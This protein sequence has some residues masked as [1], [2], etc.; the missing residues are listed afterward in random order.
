ML[1]VLP[2][3][4][5]TSAQRTPTRAGTLPRRTLHASSAPPLFHPTLCPLASHLAG[6]S[7]SGLFFSKHGGIVGQV[8]VHHFI[9]GEEEEIGLGT[10]N[11]LC[12]IP[13][14]KAKEKWLRR[15]QSWDQEPLVFILSTDLGGDIEE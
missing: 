7:G 6:A 9:V 1:P 11:S 4:P 8:L 3:L 2:T 12:I 13:N 14:C 5:V 15:V 10:F